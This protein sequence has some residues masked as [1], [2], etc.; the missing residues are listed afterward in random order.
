MPGRPLSTVCCSSSCRFRDGAPGVPRE[1]RDWVG[2]A[3]PVGAAEGRTGDGLYIGVK[4][5]EVAQVEHDFGYAAGEVDL[6]GYM[7]DGAIRK[8]VHQA[9][10]LPVFA[11]RYTPPR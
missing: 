10:N 7:S 2:D 3:A 6:D 1:V 11:S 9:R 4:Q 5:S 8:R